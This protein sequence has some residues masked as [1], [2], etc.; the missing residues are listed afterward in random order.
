MEIV[1]RLVVIASA[2]LV[3]AAAFPARASG[4]QTGSVHL[5]VA[6]PSPARMMYA[7]SGMNN[8]LTGHVFEL[9]PSARGKT[10]TLTRTR[11]AT[12][13]ED[14][15]VW[16]YADIGGTGDPCRFTTLTDDGTT[17]TGVV[18]PDDKSPRWAVVWLNTGAGAGFEF[19][20]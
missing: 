5:A 9:S 11:G 1:R 14:L 3:C 6:S 8:E 17:Q 7:M 15:D 12:G 13:L 16:F 4:E 18:C 20:Y 10:Y 2:V 19:S